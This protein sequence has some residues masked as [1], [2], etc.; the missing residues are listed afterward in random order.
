MDILI[1][2]LSKNLQL[3]ELK[4][5][6]PNRD[7]FKLLTKKGLASNFCERAGHHPIFYPPATAIEQKQTHRTK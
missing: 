4:K 1:N 3:R 5:Q 7:D 2:A 6:V